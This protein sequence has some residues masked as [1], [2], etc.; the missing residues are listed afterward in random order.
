MTE[1]INYLSDWWRWW[2]NP[3]INMHSSH[4]TALPFQKEQLKELD[5]LMF[6]QLRS[7]LS[8]SDKPD[9][10]LDEHAEIRS[11]ALATTEEREGLFMK[12]AVMSFEASILQTNAHNWEKNYGVSSADDVRKIIQLWN[13][14]PYKL[15]PWQESM[16]LTLQ[17]SSP[18]NFGVPERAQLIL[19]AYL[20]S[21]FPDFFK[22]WSLSIP[23]EV[24]LVLKSIDLL[25]EDCK[26][27]IDSWLQPA[28]AGLHQQV[29][30]RFPSQTAELPIDEDSL[31][32][33]VIGQ[34]HS[35]EGFD[36]A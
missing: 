17:S 34:L 5:F 21:F 10:L 3:L 33:D 11:M 27:T 13:Q 14:I 25:P 12:A 16:I 7:I 23:Y 36:D 35:L 20:M 18:R 8:L 24:T 32:Q 1:S 6:L 4:Q 15:K 26:S 19:G 9:P 2:S 31:E 22:R 29:L 28:F 30:E